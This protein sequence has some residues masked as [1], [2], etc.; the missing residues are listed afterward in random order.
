MALP[1]S[2][3]GQIVCKATGGYEIPMTSVAVAQGALLVFDVA[4]TES[5]PGCGYIHRGMQAG[6]GGVW[7]VSSFTEKPDAE[8]ATEYRQG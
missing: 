2:H 6:S 3:S 8:K 4:P 1:G 7:T 5:H